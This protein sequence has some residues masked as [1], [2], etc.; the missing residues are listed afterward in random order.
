MMRRMGLILPSED[1]KAHMMCVLLA[2]CPAWLRAQTPTSVR[3]EYVKFT[4]L[5]R[6]TFKN[7]RKPG[8]MGYIVEWPEAPS[9][10]PQSQR[11]IIFGAEEP[12]V[13]CDAETIAEARGYLSMR[14][15]NAMLKQQQQTP[16][17]A[18]TTMAMP[19]PMQQMQQ[20]MFQQMQQFMAAGQQMMAHGSSGAR[21]SNEIALSFTNGAGADA[22]Q[23]RQQHGY[24]VQGQQ[25]ALDGPPQQLALPGPSAGAGQLALQNRCSSDSLG[26]L[27]PQRSPASD[28]QLSPEAQAKKF[29]TAM[30][31]AVPDEDADDDDDDDDDDATAGGDKKKDLKKRPAASKSSAK[32]NTRVKTSVAKLS[33]LRF[34]PKVDCEASRKQYLFRCGIPAHAGGTPSVT[35]KFADHGGKAAAERAANKHFV[36]FKK[37]HKCA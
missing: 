7:T 32:K 17:Q 11:E 14:G 18:P 26:G 20:L 31:G 8:P 23:Q 4:A 3:A 33:E 28:A 27:T 10:L 2:S 15:N 35:F 24:Q 1:S 37:T 5:I 21:G 12:V 16:G 29:L 9:A 6:S 25:L 13:L 19:M 34:K 36:E 30:Q 22:N